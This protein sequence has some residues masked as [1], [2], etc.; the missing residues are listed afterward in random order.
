MTLLP[1][2]N[3]DVVGIDYCPQ[4]PK[5]KVGPIC[6]VPSCSRLADHAHHIWRRSF[7]S[8]DYGWVRLWNGAVI[9]NLTGLCWHHHDQVT[10]NEAKIAYDEADGC[11]YWHDSNV[12]FKLAPHPN[13]WAANTDL[14][15]TEVVTSYAAPGSVEKCRTCKRRMPHEHDE[16]RKREPARRRKTWTV[17]VPDDAEDGAAV[18]DTLISSLA[19]TLGHDDGEN[20][21]YFTLTH[22]LYLLIQNADK[23][24]SDA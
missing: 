21:R 7:I 4:F 14:V 15:K 16:K 12:Y 13:V 1:A 20:V 23:L 24:A 5:Y 8:G 2:E 11:F 18:L 9:Q 10:R 19:E 6:S 17:T 3:R 22:S